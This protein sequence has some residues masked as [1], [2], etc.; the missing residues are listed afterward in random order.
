MAKD[1][2]EVRLQQLLDNELSSSSN[3]KKKV[4]SAYESLI[5]ILQTPEIRQQL[6]GYH[7]LIF[8]C[9]SQIIL[10][11]S[12]QLFSDDE[13]LFLLE[14]ASNACV[15]SMSQNQIIDSW[16]QNIEER[17]FE[18]PD[19]YDDDDDD[20]DLYEDLTESEEEE[21]DEKV[22]I[23]KDN[24]KR[25]NRSEMNKN[26]ERQ[27]FT[28]DSFRH[29][30]NSM[31][32]Q[33]K[34][35]PL[36]KPI[37]NQS[38]LHTT[39]SHDNRN[40][41]QKFERSNQKENSTRSNNHRNF[42]GKNDKNSLIK[43]PNDNVAKGRRAPPFD[44]KYG[45]DLRLYDCYICG[46]YGHVQYDCPK[47]Q[48][49]SK[50][51][52]GDRTS[53]DVTNKKDRNQSK[54]IS[55]VSSLEIISNQKDLDTIQQVYNQSTK[56]LNSSQTI[57]ERNKTFESFL[58]L[59]KQ[60]QRQN[61][62]KL[63]KHFHEKESIFYSLFCHIA[64]N[65][66]LFTN[67][68]YSKLYRLKNILLPTK[69]NLVNEDRSI[70]SRQR[71]LLPLNT[72]AEHMKN[73]KQIQKTTFNDFQEHIL[74]STTPISTT[75]FNLIKCA[76][77][78]ST[79]MDVKC[80]EN[81]TKTILFDLK[82]DIFSNE[83]LNELH[84]CLNVRMK[85]FEHSR[86][87][88]VWKERLGLFKNDKITADLNKWISEFE[89]ILKID[90]NEPIKSEAIIVDNAMWYF[91]VLLMTSSGHLS[92]DQYEYLLK[93]A[94]QSSLFN[95]IQK[96]YFQFYLNQGNAPITIH[97]LNQLR[98]KLE[99]DSVDEKKFVYEAIKLILDRKKPTFNNEKIEHASSDI[100]NLSQCNDQ[101]NKSEDTIPIIDNHVLSRLISLME[102]ICT[103]TKTFS[104]EQLKELLDKFLYQS[105][106]VRPLSNAE[107][108]RLLS[109]YSFPISLNELKTYC[110]RTQLDLN[111]LLCLL[112]K[113][114][115][116]NNE[117]LYDFLTQ[118]II[119]IFEDRE[120]FSNEKCQE[121]KIFVQKQILGKKR[122]RLI[123]ENYV[124]FRCN[125]KNLPI[126]NRT[127]LNELLNNILLQ[128]YQSHLEFF[129]FL[130]EI[131]QSIDFKEISIEFEIVRCF[132]ST[133]ILVIAD[134]N[135][136]NLSNFAS[137]HQR[138]KTILEQKRN[139]FSSVLSE[140]QY[141]LILTR[142]TP[143][144]NVD[145]LIDILKTNLNQ[146]NF[147]NLIDFIKNE[148]KHQD[149][150]EKLIHFLL[151]TFDNEFL[152]IEQ[153]LEISNLIYNHSNFNNKSL[154]NLLQYLIELL[155]SN[156]HSSPKVFLNLIE[157]NQENNQIVNQITI[158]LTA[159]NGKYVVADWRKA[160]MN[161]LK[162]LCNRRDRNEQLKDI[163]QQSSMFNK[164]TF[165]QKLKSCWEQTPDN[166]ADENKE[167]DAIPKND[168]KN[169]SPAMHRE[170]FRNLESNDASMNALAVHQLHT[171]LLNQQLPSELLLQKFIQAI[172]IVIRNA[173]KF[174]EISCNE[175]E[176]LIAENRGKI[177]SSDAQCD[178]LL[179]EI[180][181]VRLNMPT[182]TM[183]TL[184]RLI[185][186][187]KPHERTN[188][189][190]RFI[191]LLKNTQINNAK[192]KTMNLPTISNQFYN[193]ITR[194]VFDQKFDDRQVRQC[195]TTAKNS[196]LLNNGHREKLN[197]I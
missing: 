192:S 69:H 140:Q 197:N 74:R 142:L 97:E 3:D 170:L 91:A 11:P 169:E 167:P 174:T 68:Q 20:D 1:K 89:T 102:T 94:I 7:E 183:N 13:L 144:L 70:F 108:Q 131:S 155:K 27:V 63:S 122:Y 31:S 111:D 128:D 158:M 107:Q 37:S 85:R 100:N 77:K 129:T 72:L 106:I 191:L 66:Y 93:L 186:S 4:D 159:Q 53:V 57:E 115:L 172:N 156:V 29:G 171:C 98:I 22:T 86:L 41:H 117:E 99:S 92:K 58:S 147:S 190:N 152:S 137:F 54:S 90:F 109:Y 76:L 134:A 132:V 182:D 44:N 61:G 95:S 149:D 166:T 47:K 178:Q 136:S 35:Q 146:I 26:Q 25:S 39:H 73:T 119:Q 112:K 145:S 141:K 33:Q 23:T 49:H 135:Y 127:K 8:E 193:T 180:L 64:Q 196:W 18:K 163:A 113:R 195:L 36:P 28:L 78:S 45:V 104:S 157:N 133:I 165:K 16:L 130:E 6:H 175:W 65:T 38:N 187:K 5:N 71:T 14:S 101:P 51:A 103:D 30:F 84:S 46:E 194:V 81:F 143:I 60:L 9:I 121:L 120:K 126:I 24:N 161:I 52:S 75:L 21:V 32:L 48:G 114:P 67:D 118:T 82:K 110:S 80:C 15:L 2:I 162:I 164:T 150:F 148:L 188:G 138:L 116:I 50:V 189:V 79:Y 17:T 153:T 179:M 62:E 34:N 173:H 160:M 185:Q 12:N 42:T 139:Y 87:K 56:L 83:Q 168:N 181:L 124:K 96:F 43:G 184:N 55:S 88:E 123:N 177:F 10:T 19:N 151:Y 154:K 40:D 176:T 105:I 125:K 59:I